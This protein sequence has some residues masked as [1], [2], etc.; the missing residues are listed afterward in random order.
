MDEVIINDTRIKYEDGEIWSYI[1]KGSSKNFK[2]C[3]LK[4]YMNK[5]G[6]KL[7]KI[8]K[9]HF[10]RHRV[11]YQLHNP[12]W[13]IHNEPYKNQIDHIDIDKLNNN[14][15]NLRLVSNNQNQF[16]KNCKGYYW[17]KNANKWKAQIGINGES[18]YLGIYNVEADARNS[19][20][21]AKKIYHII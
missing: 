17:D 6:Y 10:L 18:K 9:K 7:V 15:N 19:Y 16:N 13:D 21:D 5:C 14:I 1:K 12:E 2:W 20:L 4:G 11:I 8:N 3:L